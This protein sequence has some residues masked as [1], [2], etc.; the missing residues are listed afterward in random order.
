MEAEQIACRCLITRDLTAEFRRG[1]PRGRAG[2]RRRAR[3]GPAAGRGRVR[4]RG[5]SAGRGRGRGRARTACPCRTP[6]PP[7]LPLRRRRCDLQSRETNRIDGWVSADA[8]ANDDLR[9]QA[10]RIGSGIIPGRTEW[11]RMAGAAFW[12]C[13]DALLETPPVGLACAFCCRKKDFTS[14]LLV[15]APAIDLRAKRWG[16]VTWEEEYYD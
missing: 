16:C 14:P 1:L 9:I 3:G 12:W 10:R 7:A 15:M 4:R 5:A 11:E 13:A 8:K 6:A 2:R